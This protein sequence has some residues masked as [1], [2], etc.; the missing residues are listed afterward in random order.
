MGLDALTR[1]LDEIMGAAFPTAHW[2]GYEAALLGGDGL[3]ITASQPGALPVAAATAGPRYNL[4]CGFKPVAVLSVVAALEC[5]GLFAADE[6]PSWPAGGDASWRDALGHRAGLAEP[7]ALSFVSQSEPARASTALRALSRPVHRT[8]TEFS[9]V[10]ILLHLDRLARD[11]A[12]KGLPECVDDLASSLGAGRTFSYSNRVPVREIG[13]LL[14][15]DAHGSAL[16]YMQDRLPHFYGHRTTAFF[17]GYSTAVDMATFYRSLVAARGDAH[18]N[19]GL[20]SSAAVHDLLFRS[21]PAHAPTPYE[22]GCMRLVE[23][24]ITSAGTTTFGHIGYM[25]T[26]LGFCDPD[27]GVGGF[28][29]LRDAGYGGIEDRLTG[30]NT[31]MHEVRGLLGCT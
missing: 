6:V 13:C 31:F 27:S 23:H 20:I 26:S 10:A 11:L 9:E 1:L 30:W 24:G 15:T 29:L 4:M 2:V 25:R 8:S 5:A 17:G 19:E 12:G 21:P 16:P 14:D 28:A 18:H 7:D 3:V 22:A